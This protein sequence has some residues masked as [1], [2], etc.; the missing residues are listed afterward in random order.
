[1]ILA[2]CDDI[3]RVPECF[4][5][6]WGFSEDVRF[7]RKLARA[8]G[9]DHEWLPLSVDGLA[10]RMEQLIIGCDGLHGA[11]HLLFGSAIPQHV[12]S[13]RGNVL[14]EGLVYVVAG[15]GCVPEDG[16][17]GP[18]HASRW[19]VGNLHAAGS[20]E[21]INRLL[22]PDVA[23][24][25]WRRWQQYVEDR[26]RRAPA[27]DPLRKA[28]YVTQ[29]GRAGRNN[30]LTVNLYRPHA[31]VRHPLC[32]REM[33][34]WY[35]STPPRLRRGKQIYMEILRRRFPK[36]ARIQRTN[37]SGLPMAKDWLLRQWCWHSE[38]LH[39]WWAHGRYPWTRRLGTDGAAVR[40]WGF[41]HWRESGRLDVLRDRD[42]RVLRWV[43]GES[44]DELWRT[45]E[46]DPL[47]CV[48]LLTLATIELMLRW[49]E[50][51]PLPQR[52]GAHATPEL[53]REPTEREVSHVR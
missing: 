22:R 42:A 49:L 31:A 9:A 3:G 4:T 47:K 21:A 43:R 10:G 18:P 15:G 44:L 28:E 26:Y 36:F 37:Y 19:A 34:R 2:L 30:A 40:A 33:E 29:S 35:A 48:P 16:D 23:E 24:T 13:Q 51:L 52:T 14:L 46:N 20:P 45:T 53:K 1:M 8:A 5:T 27:G 39:R 41:L 12:E 50:T 25:S 38:K 32:D 7:G 17:A 6:G 11:A